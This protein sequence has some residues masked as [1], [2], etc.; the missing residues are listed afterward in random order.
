MTECFEPI[1]RKLL[2][3]PW[4]MG[5]QYTICDPYVFTIWTWIEGDGVDTSP[6]V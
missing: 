2:K 3:C 1:E 6:A 5:E 4:V